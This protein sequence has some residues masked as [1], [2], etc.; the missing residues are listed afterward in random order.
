[1]NDQQPE[2]IVHDG[3]N[4][5]VHSIFVTIQG[6]GPFAG[7]PATFVRL[8]GCNLQCPG[9]DTE[10]TSRRKMYS[11]SDVYD[12]LSESSHPTLVVVTGG[13]P[14]RQRIGGFVTKL[15]RYGFLVQIE[16]NGTLYV[17][18]PWQNHGL[19]I[20]CS[21]KTGRLN[22]NVLPHIGAFKYVLDAGNVD[23]TDGLPTRTLLGESGVARP[24]KGFDG[25]IYVQ[26][27]DTKD[28]EHNKRNEE[29]VLRSCFE[30]GYI[31]SMQ[32]HKI[33]GLE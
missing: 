25:P 9:C 32:I 18:L 14:F 33:L 23:T 17:D 27:M 10:Y 26:P 8:A 16:T 19:T 15:L 22:Q 21:P 4:V 12:R 13:E 28:P 30:H 20:V 3:D 11:P 6:E 24:P 7:H 1:M 5:E 2:G 29:A 31:Y